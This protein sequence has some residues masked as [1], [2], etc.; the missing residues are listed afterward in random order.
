MSVKD[1]IQHRLVGYYGSCASDFDIYEHAGRVFVYPRCLGVE[2][3][4]ENPFYYSTLIV[5][6]EDGEILKD[7]SKVYDGYA[8]IYP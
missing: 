6:T 2:V 4:H 7:I 3:M 1:K 8:T 5:D